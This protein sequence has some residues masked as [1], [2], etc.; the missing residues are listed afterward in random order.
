MIPEATLQRVLRRVGSVWHPE[1]AA[2]HLAYGSTGAGKSTL[3]KALLGLCPHA[4]VLVVEPKR[5]PDAVY[6]G[7]ADDPFR[8]G[9]P[10]ISVEPRFGSEQEGGGPAGLWFRIQG[11]PDR[12]DTARR[13]GAALD[14]VAN[15]GHCVLV[16]DDVKEVSKQLEL[17][18]QVES[19]LS[20]GRSAAILAILA[21]TEVSYVAG[22]TQGAMTW[23]GYS[24]G[25]LPAAKAGAELLGWRGAARQDFCA[26]VPRH[27]WIYQDH[28]WG[29][30]GPVMVQP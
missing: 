13:I 29:S 3:V 11:S 27:G 17:A 14:I 6:Q 2:H 16:L 21:T 22:R 20:L 12:A 18:K 8:W 19:I 23:V 1:R 15:E 28:E 26:S 4:R 10:V 7:P 25:S 24:G 30:A 5:N 9:R